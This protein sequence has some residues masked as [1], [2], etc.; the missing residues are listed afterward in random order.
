MKIYIY[1]HLSVSKIYFL[2]FFTRDSRTYIDRSIQTTILARFRI[3]IS[4]PRIV[5]LP[6]L[7]DLFRIK[8]K[9]IET[10]IMDKLAA[11]QLHRF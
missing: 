3:A 10:N 8:T 6:V 2:P 7:E 4:I 11:R 9:Y 1:F 5:T